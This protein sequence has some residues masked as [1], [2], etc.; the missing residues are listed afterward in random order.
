M[1]GQLFV[2][3]GDL[4]RLACDAWLVPTDTA[5]RVGRAWRQALQ[6]DGGSAGW[7]APSE[8]LGPPVGAPNGGGRAR[9]YRLP[10]TRVP[11]AT[12]WLTNVG[13]TA[14]T[15]PAWYA[16]GVRDFVRAAAASLADG[17]CARILQRERPLLA[18]PVVGTGAGGKASNAG[19]VLEPV[20]AALMDLLG[21]DDPLTASVDV[22]L[23]AFEESAYSA[24]QA[25]RR[26][27]RIRRGRATPAHTLPRAVA[28]AADYLAERAGQNELV[29]FVG[30]GLSKAAGAPLWGALLTRLAEIA[31][32]ADEVSAALDKK[33]FLDVAELI[34]R[35]LR[36]RPVMLDG[37]SVSEVGRVVAHVLEPYDRYGLGHALLA[38]TRIDQLVTTNYDQLIEGAWAGADRPLA[39]LP[40]AP[41]GGRWV[42]KLHGCVT[43][44]ERIV[45]SRSSYLRY[46]ARREALAG[47]VQGLLITKEMLFVGFSHDDDNF[48]RIADAVRRALGRSPGRRSSGGRGPTLGYSALLE[49]DPVLEGLWAG[50]LGWLDC[51]DAAWGGAPATRPSPLVDDSAFA[52]AARRLEIIL[53]EVAARTATRSHLLD[54]R[55]RESLSARERALADALYA[56]RDATPEGAPDDALWRP[57]RALLDA[58]GDR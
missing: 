50:E 45:L 19:E 5:L 4:T 40:D 54:A 51:T 43:R 33:R 10:D 20:I 47:L 57:V 32:C 6:L 44:P 41:S 39:V 52:R 25:V 29:A 49:R 7:T 26:K 36:E 12:P 30:A 55:F 31:G 23:V 56:L 28:D 14:L 15:E 48:H 17:S 3:R 35:R 58:Y 53:D 18:L 1:T 27:V 22:A 37:Q 21:G 38:S 13:G 2:V 46:Q 9:R 16:G 42:L 8:R 24:A 34:E 11:R